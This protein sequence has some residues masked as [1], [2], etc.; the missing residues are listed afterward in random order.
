MTRLKIAVLVSGRGSNLQALIDACADPAF[1]AEIAVVVSNN[2]EAQALARAAQAEIPA[3]ICDHS[4][5]RDDKAAFEDSLAAIIEQHGAQL[6]C[7]AGFMRLLGPVF[8]NRFKDRVINIHPSLLPAYKG[9]DTHARALA[10]GE[11]THGCTVHVVSP[12]MDEGSPIASRMVTILPDDTVET[13][14]A[15]VLAEEHVLYPEVV[16]EIAR[17]NVVIRQGRVESAP[18]LRHHEGTGSESHH[19]TSMTDHSHAT[20]SDAHA[21]PIADA[22]SVARAH[23][24]WASFTQG[25]LIAGGAI[26]ILLVLMALALL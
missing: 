16:A 1:P 15:R 9:L 10:A 2:P 19:G 3:M 8:L 17:G 5:F 14:A 23:A 22:Q 18:A 12:G 21:A 6:V 11:T 24:M 20:S 26:A 7:L 25:T 13:L 4:Y